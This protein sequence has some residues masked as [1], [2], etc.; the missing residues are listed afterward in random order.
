MTGGKFIT[1]EGG[2]GGGKSTQA[3]RLCAALK[4]AGVNV[5]ATREP[6]GTEGAEDI[7]ALLVTG[8]PGRWHPLTEALLH[9]AARNQHLTE[10]IRP[11]LDDGKWVVSDRF[12]DSTLAY[13]GYA[14]GLGPETVSALT[15]LTVGGFEP[16]LTLVLDLPPEAGL[17]RAASRAK[18]R[19]RQAAGPAEDRYER[20][21]PAFHAALRDAFLEIARQN[22]ERCAVV[23][24]AAP[25]D[26]VEQAIWAVVSE[27]LGVGR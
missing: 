16:D 6:G 26:Q 15:K 1:F 27:R 24:A 20:M 8:T 21:G 12:A 19:A 10:L 22:P 9:S 25:A 2:E 17:E 3:A 18:N 13:Q 5:V 4:R 7:R 23:D 11:A 14:Q